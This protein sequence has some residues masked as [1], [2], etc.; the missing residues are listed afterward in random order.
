VRSLGASALR[1][2]VPSAARSFCRPI[3]GWLMAP[4]NN[5]TTPSFI[6]PASMCRTV[7]YSS[8]SLVAEVFAQPSPAQTGMPSHP[9]WLLKSSIRHTPRSFSLLKRDPLRPIEG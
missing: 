5:W 4:W 3:L 1:S 6:N 9:L 7:Q 8:E 2:E